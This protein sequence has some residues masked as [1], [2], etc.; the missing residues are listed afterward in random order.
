M[1]AVPVVLPVKSVVQEPADSVQLAA[2]VP[3]L[4]SD[5]VKLTTPVGVFEAVVVSG[6]AALQ[7]DFSPEAMVPGL[8]AILEDVLSFP[9]F[10]LVAA[11]L[12]GEC[13]RNGTRNAPIPATMRATAPILRLLGMF[14]LVSLS[15]FLS[16]RDFSGPAILFN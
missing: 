1:V 12:E 8:H 6:T 14:I 4:G 11:G 16:G 10:P 9:V 2:T 5:D 13:N 15:F 3:M 7:I